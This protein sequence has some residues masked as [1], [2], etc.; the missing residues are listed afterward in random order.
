MMDL[1]TA[2]ARVL[3]GCLPLNPQDVKVAQAAGLVLAEAVV[4]D[5]RLPPFA[6]TAVDGFAVRAEDVAGAN[7][8]QPVLLRVVEVLAAGQASRHHL[9]AGEA[10][11]IMT[12]AP[13]PDG[14]DAVVMVEDTSPGPVQPGGPVTVLVAK[15]VS[16]RDSVRPAGDDV[17]PGDQLFQPGCVLS[18]AHVGVLA[19][20]GWVTVR[21]H[22]RPR[23]GVISTGDELVEGPQPLAAGQIRDS[24]RVSLLRL[25][26]LAG[27]V[28]VDLG[29]VR[30]DEELIRRSL[31]DA[32]EQC[33]AVV[34]SGG[35]SMG[36]FDFVKRVLN[37][38]GEINWMQVA[39]RPAKPLAFGTIAS[40]GGAT[41]IFGL[42][43]NP[44]SSMI[45][46]ELFARPGLRRLAG[47][48]DP[49]L[50]RPTLKARTADAL[51]R[52]PDGKT[53]FARVVATNEEGRYVVRNAGGQGS[54]QLA[55]MAVAN[56]LVVLPDGDGVPEGAEVDLLLLDS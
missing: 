25:V 43:G 19:S 47:H 41:P 12:G 21:A 55:V 30:D 6:N 7:G 37:Q 40:S 46:F 35:V 11:Q 18:A 20:L 50:V 39:I 27:A 42:P 44:V 23:V 16:P 34:S 13:I 1:E 53:H 45:S 24:N 9:G 2:R 4:S 3:Q 28:P 33:D 17:Q 14:A 5:Q 48:P 26:E 54:H 29:L 52:S 22:P 51:R 10:I 31:S 56:A 15:A 32:A 8:D 38:V 36:E 49:A